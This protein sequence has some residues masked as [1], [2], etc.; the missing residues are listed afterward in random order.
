MDLKSTLSE[1]SVVVAIPDQASS[2][3]AGEAVILNLKS[4]TYY[5]LN[6]VGARI[7]DLVQQPKTVEQVQTILLDEYDVEPEQCN[8]ELRQ[9]LQDLAHAGLIEVNHGAGTADI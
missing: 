7:W 5:G 3:V 2:E 4:G 9:V 1:S 6:P 8:R